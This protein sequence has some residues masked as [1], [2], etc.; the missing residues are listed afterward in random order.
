MISETCA[1]P[2]LLATLLPHAPNVLWPYV[3]QIHVRAP[4]AS[5]L[6]VSHDFRNMRTATTPGNIASSCAELAVQRTILGSMAWEPPADG[7]FII[8]HGQDFVNRS[9]TSSRKQ[10]TCVCSCSMCTLASSPAPSR[11]PHHVQ[12][13]AVNTRCVPEIGDSGTNDERSIPAK[14]TSRSP[15]LVFQSTN[16]WDTKVDG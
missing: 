1:R 16:V 14:A 3:W 13:F 4:W 9:I 6:H 11:L 15:F 12:L 8:L 2:Q 7:V 10:R 5:T